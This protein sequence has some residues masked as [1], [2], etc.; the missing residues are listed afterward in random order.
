[1]YGLCVGLH[2]RDFTRAL[3]LCDSAVKQ[4]FFNPNLYLNLAQL[5]LAFGLKADGLRHLRRGRMIDPG[6]A[7]IARALSELGRRRGPL[8]SF[9]PRDHAVNRWF[10]KALH[11]VGATA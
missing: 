11:R 2:E 6:N 8:L 10:G 1:A 4:E 3:E 9:L 5:H 7:R